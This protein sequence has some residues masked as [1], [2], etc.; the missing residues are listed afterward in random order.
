MQDHRL[1][2]GL[3]IVLLL[4]LIFPI[5]QDLTHIL[6]PSPLSGAV[7]YAVYIKP[8]WQN[9]W[10]GSY[11]E[12]MND[13]VKDNTG[14]RNDL[15]RLANQIDYSLFDKTHA[16]GVYKGT[17]GYLY[18][19][20]YINNYCGKDRLSYGH[21]LVT[22][23]KLKLIQD[24]LDNLGIHLVA[25]HAASKASFYPE[26][27]PL[28]MR[29]TNRGLNDHELFNH[30]S[31]SL[32]IRLIDFNNWFVSMKSKP[33]PNLFTKQGTHWSI[34]GGMLAVDSFIRY[35][36]YTA[37]LSVPDVHLDIGPP[38][39]HP[40]FTDADIYQALNLMTP[41]NTD[42]FYYPRLIYTSQHIRKPNMIFIADS[43]MY[44]WMGSLVQYNICSDWDFWYYFNE[45]H[46]SRGAMVYIKDFD[47]VSCLL[48][49][50]GVVLM[51]SEC[52]IKNY[53]AG[54]IES[55]FSHFYGTKKITLPADIN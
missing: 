53:G 30:I 14:I 8:T 46:S 33:Q 52:N 15:T 6:K 50:Q 20:S 42:T 11:Q 26:H 23:Y 21:W 22:L 45:V 43:Y 41:A 1:K 36:R 28:G 40:Q 31:D 9:W 32:G 12:A 51:F 55:A 39:S 3:L 44:T 18:E 49:S 24:T 13:Y 38:Y 19:N 5:F 25:I 10:S 16:E 37:K 4:L 27:F 17:D 48:K 2:N 34:Y 7:T 35:A 47:W 54:F 29:C